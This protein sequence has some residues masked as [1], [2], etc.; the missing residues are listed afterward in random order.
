MFDPYHKWL[1]IPKGKRPPTHYQ[2]LGI[3][4]DEKDAEVIKEA[5]LRQT[6]HVRVFQ[7]GPHSELCTRILNEIA[8]ARAVLLKPELRQEYDADLHQAAAEAAE[9][10]RAAGWQLLGFPAQTVLAAAGY[11]L[12]L[13]AGFS[14]SLCVTLQAV[15]NVADAARSDDS[16]KMPEEGNRTP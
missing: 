8:Q 6:S 10:A 9:R 16:A 7:T 1:G 3:A 2:L 14:A 5:A 4:P 15:R 12:V 13:I 11:V